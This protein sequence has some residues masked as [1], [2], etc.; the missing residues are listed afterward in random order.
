MRRQAPWP[1][2]P[3]TRSGTASG[4]RVPCSRRRSTLCRDG[5][6]AP[7]GKRVGVGDAPPG[8]LGT[9]G[10]GV[11]CRGRRCRGD[12][13]RGGRQGVRPG[14]ESR[15][16]RG[17]VPAGARTGRVADVDR[18]RCRQALVQ[19]RQRGG[20][21]RR[22]RGRTHEPER[23]G[24]EGCRRGGRPGRWR[25]CQR[26]QAHQ[27]QCPPEGASGPSEVDHWFPCS[28]R[29][30]GPPSG[31][32]YRGLG[33]TG[34]SASPRSAVFAPNRPAG[35]TERCSALLA[36]GLLRTSV[37]GLWVPIFGMRRL[38]EPSRPGG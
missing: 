19:A 8:G 14:R 30:G 12:R 38:S 33:S 6:R 24:R 2:P 3:G 10:V 32:L 16:G 29:R 26:R 31:G 18:L 4:P 11:A 37:H 15:R 7:G 20:G 25:L 1:A 17:Q 21:E 23:A 13:H 5:S 9:G 27:R 35:R 28:D 34:P 36:R 22:V